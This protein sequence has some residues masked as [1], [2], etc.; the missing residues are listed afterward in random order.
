MIFSILFWVFIDFKNDY[1]KKNHFT[2]FPD[3]HVILTSGYWFIYY[4]GYSHLMDALA[5]VFKQTVTFSF[6]SYYSIDARKKNLFRIY[7][8]WNG[9][10][11]GWYIYFPN[12]HI[13]ILVVPSITKSCRDLNFKNECLSNFESHPNPNFIKCNLSISQICNKIPLEILHY[14]FI[15]IP[16]QFWILLKNH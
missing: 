10:Q 12:Q 7:Y 3:I 9:T 11:N 16:I 15:F 1:S 6:L 13:S 8:A 2:H 4:V 14:I 5:K